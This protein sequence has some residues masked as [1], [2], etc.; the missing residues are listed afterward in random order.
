MGHAHTS[1][2]IQRC[3]E[4]YD[5]HG[6]KFNGAQDD[7]VIDDASVLLQI[8]QAARYGKVIA[9]HIDSDAYENTHPWRLGRIAARFPETT[10]LLIHI[11]GAALPALDRAAIEIAAEHPNITLITTSWHFAG[12][13]HAR[14]RTGL[15]WQ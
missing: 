4:E 13:P 14:G 3:F 1:A 9:F 8:E 15:L 6:I 10:F 2:T 12:A 11:G 7:Y 5:F